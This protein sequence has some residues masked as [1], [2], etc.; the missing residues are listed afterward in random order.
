MVGGSRGEIIHSSTGDR[1]RS[2]LSRGNGVVQ[3][4]EKNSDPQ[5]I[6]CYSDVT[7]IILN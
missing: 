6:I 2:C 4:H 1:F 3:T 5:K 7:V